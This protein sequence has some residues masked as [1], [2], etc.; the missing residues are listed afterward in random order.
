MSELPPYAELL[1]LRIEE[2]RDGCRFVMPFDDDVAGYPGLL[3]GG[4]I[5]GLLEFAAFTSL[6][7]AIGDPAV[8]MKPVTVTVD[9][10][11]AGI[12][13]DTFAIN[14]D[15]P[16][17]EP[18]TDEA[19]QLLELGQ[20]DLARPAVYRAY[21]DGYSIG[22][23]W[24]LAE[25]TA[26]L[27][28]T[29]SKLRIALSAFDYGYLIDNVP[30]RIDG[31]RRPVDQLDIEASSWVT[32]AHAA[33]ALAGALPRDAQAS[34][35]VLL[36]PL[37][38]FFASSVLFFGYVR[39]G[40]AYMPVIW[41][42]QAT[43]LDAIVRRLRRGQGW[44]RRA[45]WGAA[46]LIAFLLI[47]DLSR[48]ADSRGPAIEGLEDEDGR[49]VEDQAVEIERVRRCDRCDRCAGCGAVHGCASATGAVHRCG[50]QVRCTG[51]VHRCGA[52]VD[53]P[54]AGARVHPCTR[55]A[56]VAPV[57]PSAPIAPASRPRDRPE[58]EWRRQPATR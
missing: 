32:V 24:L 42:L 58:S 44:S 37:V 15:L 23:S 56:P 27:K 46:A 5:A 48:V 4:A 49:L 29:S 2:H 12:D 7:R 34:R 30:V 17:L 1:R 40:V 54:V 6:A 43:A 19:A 57:A 36:I 39:L 14:W 50:A 26:A 33:L 45:Q 38:A 53:A 52:P 16:S 41:V 28:L 35:P 21:V 55:T 22:M 47:L 11:R 10:L 8:K 51:A 31:R 13:R 3:H 25:P 9:Y 20:L 18:T